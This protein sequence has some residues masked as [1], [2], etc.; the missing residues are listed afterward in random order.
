MLIRKEFKANAR[1]TDR[2]ESL[3]CN[4]FP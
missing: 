2:T 4:I 1:S 3:R